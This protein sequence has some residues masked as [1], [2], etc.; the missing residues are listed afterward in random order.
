MALPGSLEQQ[1]RWLGLLRQLQRSSQWLS[2]SRSV[3]AGWKAY[4]H[5]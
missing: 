5:S 2:H 4:V 1:G 3:Q